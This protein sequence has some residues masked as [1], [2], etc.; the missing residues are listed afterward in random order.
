MIGYEKKRMPDGTYTVGKARFETSYRCTG[1][2]Q[3][4]EL[5][6]CCHILAKNKEQISQAVFENIACAFL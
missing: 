3:N 5:E 4:N 6:E 2:V 1:N